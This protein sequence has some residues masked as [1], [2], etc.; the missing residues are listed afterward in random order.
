MTPEGFLQGRESDE[1][2]SQIGLLEHD[3]ELRK[4]MMEKYN[5]II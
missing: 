3:P 5:I 4:K 1:D 2:A